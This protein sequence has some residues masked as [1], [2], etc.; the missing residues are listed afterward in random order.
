MQLEHE[1]GVV[2]K[3]AAEAR[4]EFD[5]AYVDAARGKKSGAGL[6]QFERAFE[7]DLGVGGDPDE[8]LGEL[9]ALAADGKEALDQRAGLARQPGRRIERRLL[10]EAVGYFGDRAA[11]DRGD[12][13]DR[14]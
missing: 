11:A 12:A 13:G 7:R 2:V 5:R 14:K 1:A 8:A 6:E 9:R 4:R 3:A 10:E